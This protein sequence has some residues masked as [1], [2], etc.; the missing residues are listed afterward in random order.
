MKTIV[1]IETGLSKYLLPDDEPVVLH[2]SMITVG[3]PPRFHIGDLSAVTAYV[4][5]GI[6]NAPDDWYGNKYFFDRSRSVGNE[7]AI[8]PSWVDPRIESEEQSE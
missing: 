2:D 7:W 5:E 1:E 4:V 6:D 3:S 8:N